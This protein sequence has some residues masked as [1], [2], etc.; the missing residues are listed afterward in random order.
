MYSRQISDIPEKLIEKGKAH[1]GTFNSIPKRIDIKGLR[2][3]Y[4]GLPIPTFLSKLRIKSRLIFFFKTD[5][6]IGLTEFFDFKIIGIAQFVFWNKESGKKNA[7][8]S[9]MPPRRRFVPIKTT[10]GSCTSFN[11]TRHIRISWGRKHQHLSLRFHLKGDDVRQ[12]TEGFIAS[13]L[14][15]QMHRDFLFVNP[16]PTSSRC[17]ATWFTC[18]QTRGV[19]KVEGEGKDESTGLA[20]MLLNRAYH[21]FHSIT[22]TVCGLGNIDNKNITFVLKASTLD[23][24]D[25]NSYNDNILIVNGEETTLPPVYMTHSFGMEKNW[26]IQDTESMVDLTFR[27]LSIDKHLFNII[28]LKDFSF[29]CYGVFDGV[30]LTKNNEKIILKNFPGIL[31]NNSMRL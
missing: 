10:E 12:N 9:F 20:V 29:S 23:A 14:Q 25:S 26:I 6:Y 24:A 13:P 11:K 4:A 1:F 17:S 2:A 8:H 3:P 16:S 31:N 27:P 7:Y 5:K 15:D 22:N 19:I 21:K 28:T 18:M 30:L